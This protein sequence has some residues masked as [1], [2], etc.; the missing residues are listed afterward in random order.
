[1]D[2]TV[3]ISGGGLT[4]RIRHIGAEL[5][6]LVG[7]AGEDVLWQAGPA[8]P[9]HA[10][11]LFPIVGKL[12]HDRLRYRGRDHRLTQHGFARDR[13]FT[14]EEQTEARARFAVEDDAETALSYPFP[15]KLSVTF[16]IADGMLA[17][18]YHLANPGDTSLAAAIGAHPAFRWPLRPG[19]AKTAHSLTFSQPE[20]TPIRR[21][22]GGLLDPAP[23][24][25]PIDGT[26]LRLEESLFADDAIILDQPRS[27]W[28]RYAAPGCEPVAVAWDGFKMLGLWS[29][30]GAEFL[31][32]E[33]WYGTASPLDFDGEF[34]D[35]PG[36]FTIAPEES[37]LFSHTI[38]VGESACRTLTG[39]GR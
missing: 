3:T 10:P 16:G 11:I 35:K 13:R 34:F 39:S 12:A 24:P 33:P 38:A 7:P 36:I 32:I 8:W 14:L 26:I 37:R 25:T 1:M 2:E 28:V 20:P 15:F 22:R 29:K 6:S 9:R 18:T 5:C 19:I 30:P 27:R 4:A 21:L 23:R 31:C 17:I